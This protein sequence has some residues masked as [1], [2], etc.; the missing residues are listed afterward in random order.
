MSCQDVDDTRQTST[1]HGSH[2][3]G[4]LWVVYHTG[5]YRSRF[6]TH[7]RPQAQQ[8]RANNRFSAWLTS[9]VPVSN[10]SCSVEPS[11]TED[12][13]SN[14]WDQY[15]N[16]TDTGQ[17]A[18][19]RTTQ[20]VDKGKEPYCSDTGDTGSHWL[21]QNWEES[22]QVSN[23][24]DS[25]SHVTDPVSVVVQN[26]GLETKYWGDFTSVCNRATLLRVLSSQTGIYIGQ[27]HRT[28]QS[29]NP[30]PNGDRADTS[31]VSWQQCD[32]TTHHVTGYYTCTG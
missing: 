7:E 24:G 28:D 2:W 26:T 23:R 30:T 14:Y 22:R 31:Q 12:S 20:Q 13:G 1:Q 11:P 21:I 6:N 25:D 18:H 32:T 29:N 8:N 3:Y 4:T 19:P 16:Q 10:V 15:Q 5:T 27:R 9:G 17:T